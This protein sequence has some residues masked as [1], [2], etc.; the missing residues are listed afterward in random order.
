MLLTELYSQEHDDLYRYLKSGEDFDPYEFSSYIIEWTKQEYEDNLDYMEEE[1][2]VSIPPGAND[3]DDLDGDNANDIYHSLSPADRRRCEEW[4]KQTMISDEP[5][6]APSYLHMTAR[7][8]LPRTTWLIHFSDHADDIYHNG[9]KYGSDDITKLGLTTHYVTGRGFK[10]GQG[11][12][13][14][15]IAQS[16][17]ALQ[18]G[19]RGGPKYG[20]EAVMFMSSGVEVLHYSDEETQVIFQGKDVNPRD[21]VYLKN[22]GGTW[23]V[24]PRNGNRPVYVN[25]HIGN[26]IKWVIA[27]YQQYRRVFA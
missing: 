20:K 5:A 22:D 7:G 15:F 2:N 10:S 21:M 27:N 16:R 8:K 11:F 17:D 1:L 13:F 9:F 12:N 19:V 4:C 6:E 18:S 23:C 3:F 25:D 24:M 26:V 14:A